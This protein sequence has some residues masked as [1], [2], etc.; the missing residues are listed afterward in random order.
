MLVSAISSQKLKTR[1]DSET[2]R[3]GGCATVL[4]YSRK[5]RGGRTAEDALSHFERVDAPII[6]ELETQARRFHEHGARTSLLL[7]F[8]SSGT[9]FEIVERD[10]VAYS[11]PTECVLGGTRSGTKIFRSSLTTCGSRFYCQK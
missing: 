7:T 10:S 5:V 1:R 8:D 9:S 4:R 11:I 6:M 3:Q 2:G